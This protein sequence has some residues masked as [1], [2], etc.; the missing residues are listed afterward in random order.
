MTTLTE[1][2]KDDNSHS[3]GAYFHIL[4]CRYDINYNEVLYIFFFY[5]AL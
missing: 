2:N 3:S 1:L 4:V 5:F